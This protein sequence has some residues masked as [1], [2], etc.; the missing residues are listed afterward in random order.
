MDQWENSRNVVMNFDVYI[1]LLQTWSLTN[2]TRKYPS[3]YSIQYVLIYWRFYTID[4]TLESQH[5]K[6]QK[7]TQRSHSLKNTSLSIFLMQSTFLFYS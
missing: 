3:T 5:S 1:I 6:I 4:L 2:F 7:D